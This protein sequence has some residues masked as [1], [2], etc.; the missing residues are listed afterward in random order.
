M[1]KPEK[2]FPKALYV[3]LNDSVDSESCLGF[4]NE[5][6]AVEDKGCTLVATYKFVGMRS[7]K[8]RVVLANDK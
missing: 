7:L 1:A 3:P 6:S 2:V 5:V 8:K 4:V